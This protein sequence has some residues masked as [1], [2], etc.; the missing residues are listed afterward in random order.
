M[1]QGTLPEIVPKRRR[2]VLNSW[3]CNK[4]NVVVVGTFLLLVRCWVEAWNGSVGDCNTLRINKVSIVGTDLDFMS[5]Y[6]MKK[7]FDHFRGYE[8]YGL[9]KNLCISRVV[10]PCED[11]WRLEKIMRFHGVDLGQNKYEFYLDMWDIPRVWRDEVL[12]DIK[13]VEC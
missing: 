3:V 11:P 12:L 5:C 9:W 13:E 7:V 2:L 8:K 4:R 6:S 10:V 1:K